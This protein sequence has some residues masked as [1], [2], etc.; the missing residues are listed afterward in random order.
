VCKEV[1]GF[2]LGGLGSFRDFTNGAA[3]RDSTTGERVSLT[4]TTANESSE[5]TFRRVDQIEFFPASRT[6]SGSFCPP[7]AINCDLGIAVT[8]VTCVPATVPVP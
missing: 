3:C 1:R 2:Y 6:G 5:S 8:Q 4:L 7:T